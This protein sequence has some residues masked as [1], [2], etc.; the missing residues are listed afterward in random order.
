MKPCHFSL[1]FIGLLVFTLGGCASSGT[2]DPS[3]PDG[4]ISADTGADTGTESEA[5]DAGDGGKI[6]PKGCGNNVL[7]TGEECDDGNLKDGDGCSATCEWECHK[8]DDCNS[9]KDECSGT[10]ITC[11]AKH[12][13][14]AGAD[15]APDGKSCGDNKACFNG[16]CM[17]FKC[18]NGVKQPDE[19]CDDG[20]S[21]DED[22][23][24]AQCKYTCLSSDKTRNCFK[25]CNPSSTCDD[26][27]HTCSPGTALQEGTVCQAGKGFC[28]DGECVP[29]TDA[30]AADSGTPPAP[31]GPEPG[32]I[33]ETLSEIQCTAEL[34]CCS[35]TGR[36]YATCYEAQMKS[37]NADPS[38]DTI[39][40]DETISYQQEFAG[41]AFNEFRTKASSCDTTIVTWATSMEGLRGI[42]QG[43]KAPG[44]SC[45]PKDL[46]NIAAGFAAGF[47]CKDGANSAC[48]P[49]LTT[50]WTCVA[51]KDEGGVCFTDLNCKPGLFCDNPGANP[52]IVFPNNKNTPMGNDPTCKKRKG[53]NEPCNETPA[54]RQECLSLTCRNGKCIEPTAQTAFC[55]AGS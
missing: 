29:I 28:R 43:T 33:C 21:D 32:H 48:L 54:T 44:E 12:M 4:N 15:K 14:E 36:S 2:S 35:D 40:K 49:T 51:L 23:C 19:E 42:I 27:K 6:T 53:I 41:T 37:C 10:T 38:L 31:P 9:M 13:C 50:S 16:K 5:G 34:N 18:G 3:A 52:D 20:N 30:G 8:N 46:A 45:V 47:S 1:W 11:N 22:G 7:D 25:E 39:A 24:T 17:D 26:T 55:L